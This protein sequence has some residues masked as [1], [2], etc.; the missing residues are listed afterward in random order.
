MWLRAKKKSKCDK[1]IVK[2]YL[3]IIIIKNGFQ[4]NFH[5]QLLLLLL[6]LLYQIYNNWKKIIKIQITIYNSI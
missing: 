2:I 6:L 1:I 5:E 3:K 4:S